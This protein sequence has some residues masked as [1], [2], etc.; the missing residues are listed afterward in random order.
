MTDKTKKSTKVVLIIVLIAII[1]VFAVVTVPILRRQMSEG[2]LETYQAYMEKAKTWLDDIGPLRVPAM[3]LLHYLSVV[4][5]IIPGEPFEFMMGFMFGTFGGL[6]L[7]LIAVMLASA[8]IYCCVNKFGMKYVNKFVNSKKFK[9][10]SF[11]ND[12]VKRDSLLFIV[13][14][15]PGTPKDLLSYFAPFTK[16]KLKNFLFITTVARIPSI[17]SSTY[18]GDKL[19]NGNFTT[20]LIVFCLIAVIGLLGILINDKILEAKNK[21]TE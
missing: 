10:W 13:F 1:I 15:I 17:V 9:S 8:T 19:Q 3:V 7:S 2:K 20:S 14:L 6:I 16:I 21:K 18:M 11:L 5:A 12:P 4:V